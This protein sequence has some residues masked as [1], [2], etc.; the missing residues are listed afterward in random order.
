MLCPNLLSY[1]TENCVHGG[2][3]KENSGF[4]AHGFWNSSKSD[5]DEGSSLRNDVNQTSSGK[6]ERSA[7]ALQR[8][9]SVTPLNK[10]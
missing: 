5:E 2:V 8:I 4:L 1:N 10:N 6:I 9:F 7:E 3:K